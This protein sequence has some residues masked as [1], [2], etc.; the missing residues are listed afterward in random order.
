MN[1]NELELLAIDYHDRQATW[2]QFWS[3]N[4]EIVMETTLHDKGPLARQLCALVVAGDLDG[5]RPTPNS[6]FGWDEAE[7]DPKPVPTLKPHDT[8]TVARCQWVPGQEV[9][10]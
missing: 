4:A 7:A 3:D 2:A 10:S 8:E 1:R 5:H 6:M 9:R